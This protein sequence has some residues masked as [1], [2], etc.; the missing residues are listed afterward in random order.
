MIKKLF[1]LSTLTLAMAGC[2]TTDSATE[3]TTE[4]TED[5]TEEVKVETITE[6]EVDEARERWAEAI[7]SIGAA[8]EEGMEEATEKAEEVIETLYAYDEGAVLFKPT[9]AAELPFRATKEEALSY[10]VGGD[11]SEDSGFA[12]EPW[13]DI[14]FDN[15]E[16]IIDTDSAIASG[17]YYFT[18]G[19]TGDETKVEYTFGFIR[20]DEGNLRINLHHSSLP[21]VG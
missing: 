14:H 16:T 13:T 8:S 5:T 10:F 7:I 2:S 1:L 12:L 21:Y 15:H 18:S 6:A 19:E 11:I 9:K 17:E 20:D 4:I 3:S